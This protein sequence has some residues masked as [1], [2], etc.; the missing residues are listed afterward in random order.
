MLVFHNYTIVNIKDYGIDRNWSLE[1]CNLN[2][3]N[4]FSKNYGYFPLWLTDCWFEYSNETK[5]I[6]LTYHID[7]GRDHVLARMP[8]I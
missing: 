7:R 1:G 5:N 2:V 8:T 6:I 3:Y 4:T